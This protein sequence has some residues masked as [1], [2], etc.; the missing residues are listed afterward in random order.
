[1]RTNTEGRMSLR[2]RG[3]RGWGGRED[4]GTDERTQEGMVSELRGSPIGE[5][6][7]RGSG[8]W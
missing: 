1:M 4:A 3:R 8:G 7:R 2:P 6:F 5:G